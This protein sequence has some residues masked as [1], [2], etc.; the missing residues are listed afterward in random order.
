MIRQ[1][2]CASLLALLLCGCGDGGP[3]LCEV[4][5][6]VTLDGKPLPGV[7][8]TFVPQNV[9]ATMISYG[10][11]DESGHYE[12]AFTASKT[13]AIPA[14]HHVRVD[15]PGGKERAK[16]KKKYL[17]EGSITKEVKDGHNVIDIELTSD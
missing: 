5:G 11:S 14:T 3:Q 15:I 8:L 16:L 10:L 7:E 13:G 1:A 4:E 17:P 9:P 12:L 6:T 2:S